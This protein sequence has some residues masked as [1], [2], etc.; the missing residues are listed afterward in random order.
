MNYALTDIPDSGNHPIVYMDISLGGEI[1]GRIHIRLLRD[2][3]PAGV[4]N[5][6]RIATGQTT[7]VIKKGDGRYRFNREIPRSY[8]NCKFYHFLHNNYIISGDIY[9]NSGKG[10]GTIY[11]DQPIPSCLLGEFF[12]PHEVKGLVSLI[13]FK[14]A[15]TGETYY[16][17]TFL[18]TLDNAKDTNIL[19]EL[20]KDHVVIGQICRGLDIIEKINKMI[21]PG[22]GKNYPKYV[23]SCSGI[24]TNAGCKRRRPNYIKNN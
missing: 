5:F 10:A 17:S 7:R 12:Y 19:S 2:A 8:K 18:I 6:I 3:F 24:L 15:E 20:D 23:I 22:A 21:T 4:E 11:D 9:Y 16:D 13:P 14:D 1:L